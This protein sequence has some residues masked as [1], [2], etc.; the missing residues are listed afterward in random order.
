MA[1]TFDAETGE[2]T[3]SETGEVVA[4]AVVLAVLVASVDE[5]LSPESA[6]LAG[7]VIGGTISVNEWELKAQELVTVAFMWY[8]WAAVGGAMN[9]TDEQY[10]L[11]AAL[12]EVQMGFL[13]GFALSISEDKLSE[14]MIAARLRLYFGAAAQA[15]TRGRMLLLGVP[16]T[17]V[18]PGD[19]STDCC[20]N[21]DCRWHIKTLAGIGNFDLIWELGTV[22]KHC[23]HC[24]E[25]AREWN[26]L[27]VRNGTFIDPI[28]RNDSRL[29]VQRSRRDANNL[30]MHPDILVAEL[31]RRQ[32]AQILQPV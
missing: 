15:Y 8:L 1:Y 4:A 16:D 31:I 11:L 19:C 7:L 9:A 13:A 30:P 23:R 24:P 3:D 17:G 18:H 20:S 26:P 14:S 6:L 28:N 29:F 27:R 22:E 25:R 5:T 10:A 21:C 2:Y 32:K 12:L